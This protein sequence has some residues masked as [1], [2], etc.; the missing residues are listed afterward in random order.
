MKNKA[1]FSNKKKNN[2]LM[3]TKLSNF[4]LNYKIVIL[5]LILVLSALAI[6]GLSFLKVT[7]NIESFFL[8]DDPI[9]KNQNKFEKLFN[10]NDFAG[11][12]VENDNVFSR[13]SLTLI[14]EIQ[15]KLSKNVPFMKKIQ[16]LTTI[17]KPFQDKS[18]L[19]FENK[20]LLSNDKELEHFK[21]FCNGN[22][23][24]KS[25]LFSSNN[26]Q[27]WILIKLN[28]YPSKKDWNEKQ[29]PLF[30]V[31]Q[32]IYDTVK[33]IKNE[34][35]I[36][37]AT[38]VPVYAYRKVTEMMEDLVFILI[39]G[40]VVALI[41]SIVILHSIQGVIGTLLVI[42]LS[43]LSVLGIQGWL[44]V[45]TDSAFIS[46][47]ILLAMGV[48]IGYTVHITRFFKQ[49]LIETQDRK[50]SIIYSLKKSIK[51][52]FF[53]AFTT[54]V[55][56]LSFLFV[57]INPIQ[58][59]GITSASSILAVFILSITIF[60][61]I[62][63]Y[64]KNKKDNINQKKS[65]LLEPLLELFSNWVL[66]HRI[67]TSS[68]FLIIC[69]I[70]IYGIL[71]LKVDFDAKKVTGTKLQ[72]MK[73]QIHVGK[74]EIATSE[75]LNLTITIPSSNFKDPKSLNKIKLLE[76]RIEDLPLIKKT[77]SIF[78]II[79][80]FNYNLHRQNKNFN[81]IPSNKENLNS[82][83]SIC[84]KSS[85]NPL[86]NWTAENYKT[87]RLD[88]ELTDFSSGEIENNIKKINN[89]IQE[90]FPKKTEHF[91]SGYTYQM[92]IM[93]QYI[94]RGLIKSVLTA[95]I[96]ITILMI[97]IFRSFKFGLAAMI[98]NIFP[99]II[100][101]GIM[102]LFNIPLEF[103][104]MTVAPMIM[105]LAV[106]DT[107]HL[108]WHFKENMENHNDFHRNIKDTFSN[109]GVAI[110]ETTL[111]LCLTFSVFIFSQVNS[112]INMGILICSGMLAAYL[113]DIFITPVIIKKLSRTK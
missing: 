23:S 61:I 56:L 9:I 104:T 15:S 11:I 41:L 32:S 68:I 47:P 81:Q 7:V 106:D 48:S 112:I 97:I 55:A 86:E 67:T 82:L 92:T 96:M 17:K 5:I 33:S 19:N 95:M 39:I 62:M 66:K 25:V 42:S 90:I 36:L 10:T 100:T 43:I 16:S 3:L 2:N 74:S 63:S 109:V 75:T 31:G 105:G 29:E 87:T 60:P 89:F 107:I 46:V 101:G 49:H 18:Y 38:G 21:K 50:S 93:N 45:T 51:P 78:D 84:E 14:N 27:A 52:I 70:S 99:V 58:W 94:T 79:K 44:G 108:I 110:T 6:P 91:F 34:K 69:V 57:E 20:N 4:I 72:H 1:N 83:I 13:E 30:K 40:A 64:G 77:N 8:E 80:N 22:D 65:S 98:P 53:T 111:I 85:H 37:T 113:S 73:D 103:V 26:K 54:I 102:G 12:L 35:T 24:L 71:Q 28:P 59:V 88:I 76:K